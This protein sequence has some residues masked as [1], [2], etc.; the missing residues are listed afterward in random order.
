MHIRSACVADWAALRAVTQRAYEGYVALIGR[1]PA[2]M[3]EDYEA[4]IARAIVSVAEQDGVVVGLIVV[5]AQA[6]HL[7][8]ENVAVE[9]GHQH[10]GIGRALLGHAEALAR[11]RGVRELR[12]YTNA[13][14]ERNL[15]LYPRLGY[16]ETGRAPGAGFRRVYFTKR[17][18]DGDG[19][20]PPPPAGATPTAW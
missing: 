8:I 11:E 12:L 2:P 19:G 16:A 7:L 9:P 20:T 18:R 1:R 5:S 10:I 6:D 3:D 4:V 14:M 13:A 17:L 15:R